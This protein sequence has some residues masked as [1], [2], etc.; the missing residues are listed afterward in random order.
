MGYKMKM[1]HVEHQK[2]YVIIREAFIVQYRPD[3]DLNIDIPTILGV[4][5]TEV[6]ARTYFNNY[7]KANLLTEARINW[8]SSRS[9]AWVDEYGNI[10]CL[11]IHEEEID[12]EYGE[13]CYTKYM[14]L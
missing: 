12:A 4:F 5:S 11:S 2:C 10:L 7:C 3:N 1:E 8:G 9:T 14:T 13:L 6:N